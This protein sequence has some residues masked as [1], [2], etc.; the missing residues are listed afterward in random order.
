[1]WIFWSVL[2]LLVIAMFLFVWFG[3]FNVA[4]SVQHSDFTLSLISIVRDRSIAMR[5]KAPQPVPP[6]MTS[7]LY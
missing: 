2:V 6:L 7:V 4:A 1:M 5:A 3:L